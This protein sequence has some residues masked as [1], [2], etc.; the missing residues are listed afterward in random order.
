MIRGAAP[1]D[2]AWFAGGPLLTPLQQIGVYKEQYRLRL[3]DAL[4]EEV[5]GLLALAGD[6]AEPLL[7]RYLA[8]NP[9]TSWTLNAVGRPLPAWLTEQDVP[10]AWVDIARLDDAVSRG[11]EAADGVAVRP[12]DLGGNPVLVLQPPVSLLRLRYDVHLVRAA[13]IA[14]KPLP[15]PNEVDVPLVVFRRNDRMRHLAV[16][17]DAWALLACFEAPCALGVALERVVAGGAD[18]DAL[19]GKLA[20]WFR[21]FAERGLVQGG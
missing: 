13:V 2:E 20:G 7:R 16:E 14:G 5:P 12:E 6:A 10:A 17:P 19:L 9:S 4:V 3:Y 18:P 11:F 21:L 15:E 8:E 1:L